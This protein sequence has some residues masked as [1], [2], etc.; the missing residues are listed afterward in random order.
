MVVETNVLHKE[1]VSD[2]KPIIEIGENVST[3]TQE[4]AAGYNEEVYGI[5]EEEL[6]SKL[7]KEEDDKPNQEEENRQIMEQSL[8]KTIITK[9]VK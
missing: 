3:N 9:M 5:E 2:F 4:H 8:M 1:N 7:G 6:G